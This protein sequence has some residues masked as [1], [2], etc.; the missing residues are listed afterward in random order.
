M[1][2]K[3]WTIVYFPWEDMEGKPRVAGRFKTTEEKNKFLDKIYSSDSGWMEEKLSII[4][5]ISNIMEYKQ[6]RDKVLCSRQKE[7]YME[8]LLGLDVIFCVYFYQESLQMQNLTTVYHQMDI[9]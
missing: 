3:G 8:T 1:E 2:E 5:I 9:R 7:K 4:S 6:S